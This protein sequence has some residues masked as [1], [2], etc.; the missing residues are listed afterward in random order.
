MESTSREIV[1]PLTEEQDLKLKWLAKRAELSPE[2]FMLMVLNHIDGIDLRQWVIDHKR[3]WSRE[4]LYERN[5]LLKWQ[6]PWLY[7]QL[8]P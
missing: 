4:E 6:K 3:G 2:E 1:V 7:E 5:S 8:N